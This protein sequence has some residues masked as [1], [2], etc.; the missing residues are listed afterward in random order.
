MNAPTGDAAQLAAAHVLDLYD[1][2]VETRDVASLTE[3]CAPDVAWCAEQAEALGFRSVVP[4]DRPVESRTSH[5]AIDQVHA[6]P[7]LRGTWR[8]RVDAEHE[9][10]TQRVS[11]VTGATTTQTGGGP[12]RYEMELAHRLT[13]WV[14]LDVTST[15]LT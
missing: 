15:P 11:E 7:T 9:L 6:E 3:M 8:V 14:V 2:A 12:V 4:A 1:H 10:T 13:G 5:H